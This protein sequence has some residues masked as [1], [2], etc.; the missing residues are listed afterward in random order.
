MHPVHGRD[1]PRRLRAPA[2]GRR[3][4]R[5]P[6]GGEQARDEAVGVFSEMHTAN[7]AME[8]QARDADRLAPG[9]ATAQRTQQAHARRQQAAAA[10]AAMGDS[11]RVERDR[12]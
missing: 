4:P 3:P 12:P 6:P 10:A 8:S 9:G 11:E 1:G 2:G 5:H 7:D